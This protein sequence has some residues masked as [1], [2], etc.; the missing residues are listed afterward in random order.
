[1]MKDKEGWKGG[2]EGGREGR[3]RAGGI[4]CEY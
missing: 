4:L 1:M 3:R 2:W